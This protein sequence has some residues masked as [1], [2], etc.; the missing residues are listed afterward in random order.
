MAMERGVLF[1]L[2]IG[3]FL[4]CL[5]HSTVY[6]RRKSLFDTFQMFVV[7]FTWKF[8]ECMHFCKKKF[9]VV[10]I[11][12]SSFYF[13]YFT[14]VYFVLCLCPFLFCFS[15]WRI[16]EGVCHDGGDFRL[17][18]EGF[19]NLG[20]NDFSRVRGRWPRSSWKRSPWRQRLVMASR[21]DIILDVG[22]FC[23]ALHLI[24]SRD[25]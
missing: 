20:S 6:W 14:L 3:F 5:E 16:R 18:S 8:F 12:P 2:L 11:H 1:R 9:R 24:A 22:F 10:Q 4:F 23:I 17:V 7:F 25:V 15:D 13:F 21:W 19:S